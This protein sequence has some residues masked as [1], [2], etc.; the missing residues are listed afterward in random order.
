MS[1]GRLTIR[2]FGALLSPRLL[3]A[4]RG[5]TIRHYL[6]SRKASALS[7]YTCGSDFATSHSSIVLSCSGLL[8]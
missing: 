2:S 1:R 7:A 5:R 3:W 6:P 4:R 8:P